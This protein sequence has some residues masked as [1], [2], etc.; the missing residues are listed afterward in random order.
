MKRFVTCALHKVTKNN[1]MGRPCSRLGCDNKNVY[2]Y[3]QVKAE[4]GV[5][6]RII[7]KPIT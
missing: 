7:L 3:Q 5:G 1:G 2:F 6:M 4:L